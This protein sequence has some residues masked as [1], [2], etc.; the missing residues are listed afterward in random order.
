V[1]DDYSATP[2]EILLNW[3]EVDSAFEGNIQ[4]RLTEAY[5]KIFYFMQ[6]MQFYLKQK[7]PKT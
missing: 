2:H 5:K 7:S 3:K 6:L 1:L 4:E